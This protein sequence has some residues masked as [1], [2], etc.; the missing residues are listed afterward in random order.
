VAG[1]R[2]R[3]I[4][5]ALQVSLDGLIEGPDGEVDWIGSWEDSFDLL[6]EI[7]TL[8]LGGGAYPGYEQYWQAILA[9]PE[10]VQPLTGKVPSQDEVAYARFA[11]TTPHVVLSRTLET[12]AWQ[13]TR[14]VRDVADVAALKQQPG[15]A[16][17][18]VGGA[19]LVSTL[20]NAG[21]VDQLRLTVHPVVLGKGKA[22]FKDVEGR[23]GLELLE[24]RR[25]PGGRVSLTYDLA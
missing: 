16:I 9:N 3:R 14:I 15:K 8:V 19:S 6:P 20:M 12:V 1:G 5:A 25:L 17:H 21:L 18:A 22:L 13:T 24:T 11:D 2:S 10:G 7:D 4:I 23:H